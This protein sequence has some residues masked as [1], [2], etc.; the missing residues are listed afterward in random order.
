GGLGGLVPLN[1][2]ARLDGQRCSILDVAVAVQDV[3]VVAGP[4]RIGRDIGRYLDHALG[5][6]QRGKQRSHR[7]KQQE[8]DEIFHGFLDFAQN[9]HRGFKP[10]LQPR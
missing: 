6:H 2:G 10:S 4:G 7:Q 1:D 5:L 8:G 9:S 3:D